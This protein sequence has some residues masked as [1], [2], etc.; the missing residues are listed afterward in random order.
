M[1]LIII[2]LMLILLMRVILRLIRII[3]RI[4]R[5]IKGRLVILFRFVSPFFC[6]KS[7]LN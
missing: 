5:I 1:L 6:A 2:L 3:M 7:E 4:M